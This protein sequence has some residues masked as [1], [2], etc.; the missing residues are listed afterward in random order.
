[1]TVIPEVL[2]ELA[3]TVSSLHHCEDVILS[4]RVCRDCLHAGQVNDQVIVGPTKA[5]SG[6]RVTA[7]TGINADTLGRA[8]FDDACNLLG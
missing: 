3:K 1:M 7:G 2:S 8:T 6:I 5:V 4:V